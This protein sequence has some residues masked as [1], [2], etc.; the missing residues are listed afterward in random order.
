ME[1]LGLEEYMHEARRKLVSAGI[2]SKKVMDKKIEP[3][4]TH[5]D[6]NY[7]WRYLCAA[8]FI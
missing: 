6:K 8:Q 5:A 7:D 4:A 1:D 2:L 3:K